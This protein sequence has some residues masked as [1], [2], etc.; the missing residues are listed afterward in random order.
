MPPRPGSSRALYVLLVCHLGITAWLAT[1][2]SDGPSRPGDPDAITMCSDGVDN[3]LDGLI[4]SA[5]PNCTG[6]DDNDEFDNGTAL[7]M[8]GM[9]NDGDGLIDYPHDPGCL[10]P[11]QNTGEQDD[12][13]SGPSCPECGNGVDDDDDGEIDFA[14]MDTGCTSAADTT[15]F[16]FDGDACGP[17]TP[18][19]PL[20]VSGVVTGALNAGASNTTTVCGAGDV[21]TGPEVAYVVTLDRPMQL[22]AST[23]FP[24]TTI[25]TV[26]YVRRVCNDAGSQVACSDNV[27]GANTRSTISI[28]LPP[29]SYYIIVDGK[30][31]AAL[32]AYVLVVNLYAGPGEPCTGP[33]QCAPGFEC[34]LVAGETE[35]TCERPVCS[36]GRDDDMD[37]RIDYPL[38]PGC[39]TPTDGTEQDPCPGA[40]CPACA[41]GA[42]NDTDGQTDYPNDVSCTSASGTSEA[43]CPV[44]TNPLLTVTTGSTTGTTVGASSSFEPSCGFSSSNVPDRV[45][46]LYVRAPLATLNVNTDNSPLDT[47]MSI[48]DGLCTGEVECD[49]DDGGGSSFGASAITLTGVAPG[50]YAVVIDG[51]SSG[52]YNLNVSGTYAAAQA[53]DP[54]MP[55][56]RCP[57]GY[58][59]TGAAG[60]ATCQPAACNDQIDADG[61]GFPGYPSDPG[62]TSTNDGDE[63]DDCPS[64]PNCPQCSNDLDDDN[65]GQTD[66]PADTGC[67]AASGANEQCITT[68]P[69]RALTSGSLTNQS[70]TGLA[71]DFDLTCGTNGRDEVFRVVIDHPIDE[72]RVNTTGSILDAQ[73]AI[74]SPTCGGFDLQCGSDLFLIDPAV[75]EYFLVVD[76][77]FT[78][79]TYN[80]NVTG[81]YL[82]NGRCNPTSIFTCPVGFACQ[83]AAGA[84]TCTPAACNDTID[85]DGD[86]FPG[87]P[88]DPGCTS[89]SD[90]DETDTCPSGPGCPACA[91]DL[92]DDND[93]FTDY[94]ADPACAAASVNSELAPCT[95][96]DPVL[97]F[98]SNIVGASTAGDLNDVL[99]SCGG[100]GRDDIYRLFVTQAL[101]SLTVDTLGSD[102]NTALALRAGTCNGMDLACGVNNFGNMDSRVQLTNVAVG[103]YFIV[104]D[105]QFTS[106]TSYNLNVSGTLP[107]GA[108]CNPA[109]TSFVCSPGF[110]C[111]GPAGSE[112]CI[113]ARCNDT[114]D[115][116]GDGRPGYPT[117][118]GCLSTADDDEADNCPSGPG[119]PVCA[120]GLDDDNDTRIDY[121]LDLGCTAASGS[122][123]LE[124]M[125]EADPIG[126]ITTPTTTGDT[127]GSTD[128]FAPLCTSGGAERV[129]LLTL[130][131][132]VTTLVIDSENSALF[133]TVLTVRDSTCGS[134]LAC[135]DDMGTGNWSLI[136]MSNVAAGTYAIT[137]EGF[138]GAIGGYAVNVRGT[139]AAGQ[140]CTHPLFTSGV[141]RCAGTCNA[142]VC[143]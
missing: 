24:G 30:T 125:G 48:Y 66:Y 143:N 124:C 52:A 92:D 36:D 46:M 110:A 59:C 117:D 95:S 103:E 107:G 51:Y 27:D 74:R 53:C 32:G 63:S 4:D 118:P 58:A 76:D 115:A 31:P 38:D 137:I 6:P 15:E 57:T 28:A 42:D 54:T 93:G 35:E 81:R 34:R 140:A 111:H 142:G 112:T 101:T 22:V 13:P 132:P 141:L 49:D 130:P 2:C 67:P 37:G 14:G 78:S 89:T 113:L 104:V 129:Y 106:P 7:C 69:V 84:E 5:D 23:D 62:C 122:T 99:L 56:F 26:V 114:I 12:C 98:N 135:D 71:D 20:P 109:S 123:E 39:T 75:G 9:D 44:E 108:T 96:A 61:D 87:Y 64:G 29:G 40:G 43:D 100:N 33:E 60:A 97:V 70:M 94:P 21:G 68:D 102:I 3:D 90:G 77:Q 19:S 79:G 41:D 136:T 119:C 127:T 83:G 17:G 128:S 88:T 65:D 55:M 8:D 1:G 47:I 16:Q 73:L 121:P 126:Q 134:E 91:N 116:D 120:N 11:Q 25:D 80:L 105:D 18:V 86:G 139:V 82:G 50:S 131:V 72:I 10:A 138:F 133:D 45:H 85:A